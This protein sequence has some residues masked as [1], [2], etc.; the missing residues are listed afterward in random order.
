MLME[1]KKEKTAKKG[2]YTTLF[3]VIL[4]ILTAL[5][6]IIVFK[7]QYDKNTSLTGPEE[8]KSYDR[9]YAFITDDGSSDFWK[10]VYG[11]AKEVGDKSGSFVEEFAGDLTED[12][13]IAEKVEIAVKS[14][15]DGIILKG[16]GTNNQINNA[17]SKAKD[18]GIPVVLV[19]DD[20][21][22]SERISYVGASRY[23]LGTAYGRQALELSK[24]LLTSQGRVS[25]LVLTG[26]DTEAGTQNLLISTIRETISSDNDL[27]NRI[28]LKTYSVNDSGN[29]TAEESVRNIFSEEGG[30]PDILIALSESNTNCAYQAVIDYNMAGKCNIIGYYESDLILNAIENEVIYSTVSTDASQMGAYCT[31]ALDEYLDSGYVN[32]FFVVDTYVINK[33]N[34]GR[35]SS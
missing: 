12:Y 1:E 7:I 4:M 17:I 25:I 2:N 21:T 9:Y 11:G 16:S 19:D 20:I 35:Y 18:A 8:Y 22:G 29:F 33:E 15:V 32:E 6:G 24:K 14:K 3:L 5:I 26:K 31:R 27:R 28:V 23:D 34:L 10:N 13:T 30:A